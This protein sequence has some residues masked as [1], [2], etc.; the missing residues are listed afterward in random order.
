MSS[1]NYLSG[2]QRVVVSLDLESGE[3][4]WERSV[5]QAPPEQKWPRSS[6]ATPTAAADGEQVFAYFGSGVASLDF[7]GHILWRRKFPNYLGHTR[8]GAGASPVLTD[9]LVILLQ[10]SEMYQDP[11]PSWMAAFDK[12]TGEPSWRIESEDMRDSYSTPI[13]VPTPAGEQL[14]AASWKKLLAFDPASGRRLW[15][16]EYPMWQ[17]VASLARSGDLLAVTGGAHGDKSLQLVRAPG[18]EAETRAELLWQSTRTVADVPSPVIHEGILFTVTSGGVLTSYDVETGEVFWRKR[19]KGEYYA[20]LV[21]GDGKVYATNTAGATTVLVAASEYREI[22]VSDSAEGV[23]ASLAIAD[24][25]LLIR[26]ARE[27]FFIEGTDR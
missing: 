9:D 6:Y 14:V 13:L 17:V 24:G 5:L 2:L 23:Y 25:G 20:S 4:L 26:S 15:S 8:Y 11:T 16:F 10:E 1:P 3:L 7:D 21:A 12:R 27:L 22:S 19:L 18:R